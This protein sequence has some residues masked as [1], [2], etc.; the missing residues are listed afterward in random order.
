MQ[1]SRPV[2]SQASRQSTMVEIAQLFIKLAW[3]PLPGQNP[4]SASPVFRQAGPWRQHEKTRS[5]HVSGGPGRQ[6]FQSWLT[7]S[8]V[9][10]TPSFECHVSLPRFSVGG[11]PR[12]AHLPV[13]APPPGNRPK[14][15]PAR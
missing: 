6:D 11:F 3:I 4:R 7:F 1:L 8:D 2:I 10:T 9:K 5:E 15:N 12:Q 14:R 13:Q